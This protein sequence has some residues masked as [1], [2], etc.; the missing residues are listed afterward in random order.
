M[1]EISHF[2]KGHEV[3]N[4]QLPPPTRWSAVV[5][6]QSSLV[7]GRKACWE[8]FC[9]VLQAMLNFKWGRAH[10]AVSNAVLT[11]S[12]I[13]RTTVPEKTPLCPV[14][15]LPG[16]SALHQKPKE[17]LLAMLFVF[18]FIPF[19]LLSKGEE[20]EFRRKIRIWNLLTQRIM[21]LF[22]SKNAL[23]VD[24]FSSAPSLKES[25]RM[26]GTKQNWEQG[27]YG[28]VCV[29]VSMHVCVQ[30]ESSFL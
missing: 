16:Q 17:F 24:L 27:Q 14:G 6:T 10:F 19:L 15:L 13:E 30:T 22:C 25:I 1:S 26:L 20:A 29:C 28:C 7:L 2:S 21:D 9:T 12:F 23:I 4:T 8:Q 5:I 11:I 3:G 18:S